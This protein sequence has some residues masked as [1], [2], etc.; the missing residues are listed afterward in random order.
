MRVL[1]VEDDPIS[2]RIL[3]NYLQK[4]GYAHTLAQDGQEAWALLQREDHAIVLTDWLMPDIDGLELIRRIREWNCPHGHIYTILL[5]AKSQKED[6]VA[7]MEA[8]ADDF[9]AKPFDRDEL[10]VRLQEGERMVQWD[11]E[12]ARHAVQIVSQ[13]EIAR[14]ALKSLLDEPA[15]QSGDLGERLRSSHAAVEAAWQQARLL[16]RAVQPG[17]TPPTHVVPS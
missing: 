11:R 16:D 15:A 4:W 1:V 9:L 7:A 14:T 17:E 6:L 12:V 2:Q 5:T 13:L 10:R 8:G 3:T